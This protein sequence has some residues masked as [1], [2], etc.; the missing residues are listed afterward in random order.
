MEIDDSLINLINTKITGFKLLGIG[1]SLRKNSSSNKILKMVVDKSQRYGANTSILEL[2]KMNFPIFNPNKP[3]EISEDIKKI[4][5]Q[6][7]NADAFILATAA[8]F[9]TAEKRLWCCQL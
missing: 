6:I 4:N 2:S 1:S 9:V 7:I 8:S 3:K 5:A